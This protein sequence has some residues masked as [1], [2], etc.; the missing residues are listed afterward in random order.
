MSRTAA[1]REDYFRNNRSSIPRGEG[2]A[3]AERSSG[4]TDLQEQLVDHL[5]TSASVVPNCMSPSH[6]VFVHLSTASITGSVA[7][8]SGVPCTPQICLRKILGE[9]YMSP[10]PPPS[11]FQGSTST[12]RSIIM[13]IARSHGSPTDSEE[14][15]SNIQRWPGYATSSLDGPHGS[16][17]WRSSSPVMPPPPADFPSSDTTEQSYITDFLHFYDSPSAIHPVISPSTS[18]ESARACSPA[19]DGLHLAP[20][21]SPPSYNIDTPCAD[22]SWTFQLLQSSVDKPPSIYLDHTSSRS[23]KRLGFDVL[24]TGFRQ[25]HVYDRS[26]VPRSQ[27]PLKWQTMLYHTVKWDLEP[28]LRCYNEQGYDHEE[29]VIYELPGLDYFRQVVTFA[30]STTEFSHLSPSEGPSGVDINSLG[31]ERFPAPVLQ[32]YTFVGRESNPTPLLAVDIRE[33]SMAFEQLT[34]IQL[35]NVSMEMEDCV[36]ITARCPR[37]ESLCLS[38][39]ISKD[40]PGADWILARG[41]RP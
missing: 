27:Y 4:T 32:G 23:S 11:S 15:D 18:S 21:S 24:P 38:G 1:D 2:L 40:T 39:R 7:S 26:V 10:H 36:E 34:R 19:D 33:V 3:D 31:T 37:L 8:G 6:G 16:R 20:R 22:P 17:D 29:G 9:E 30:S 5:N 14:P 35:R 12:E 41:K 28:Q 25:P 13:A